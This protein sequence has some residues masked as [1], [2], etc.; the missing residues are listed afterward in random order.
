MLALRLFRSPEPEAWS[1]SIA[2]LFSLVFPCL[3]ALAVLTFASCGRA[4]PSQSPGAAP[5][6]APVALRPSGPTTRPLTFEWTGHAQAVYQVAIFDQVQRLLYSTPVRGTRLP[7]PP[8]LEALFDKGGTFG[9]RATLMDDNDQPIGASAL[10]EF[11][12]APTIAP[13]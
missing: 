11:T 4:A 10:T 1:R 5:P 9:W 13:R 8:D 2:R 3:V 7:S 12:I 6:A